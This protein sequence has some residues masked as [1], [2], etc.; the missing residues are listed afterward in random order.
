MEAGFQTL[1]SVI[2]DESFPEVDLMLRRGR[3]IGRDDGLL[4]E[5]LVDAQTLLEL[6]YHRFGCELVQRSDG[7]F[8]LLP[9]G[10]RLGRRQLSASE[11]LVGQTLALL[12]LDPSTLQHSGVVSRDDVLQRLSG[13][14]GAKRLFFALNPRKRSERNYIEHTAGESIRSQMAEVLRRLAELGFI[15]I[16]EENRIR[17]RP[18]LMRFAD[19]VR[20]LEDSQSA[21]EQLVS[22]GE[23]AVGSSED[24]ESAQSEEGSDS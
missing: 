14:L 20:G 5:Y 12:Y 22:R 11:M 8:Y 13:L 21:L 18:A 2:G 3:H 1:E 17:M 7:F 24:E 16:F 10:D 4:Y 15:D 6:F 19:P 9:T 23:L